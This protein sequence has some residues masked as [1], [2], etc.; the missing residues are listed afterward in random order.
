MERAFKTNKRNFFV[1]ILL[2]TL[3]TIFLFIAVFFALFIP[4]FENTIMDRKR[5]MIKELTNSAWSILDKWHKAEEQG[6]TT[7]EKAQEM[8]ISQIQSLRYGEEAKDYFWITDYSPIMI[9]HPYRSELNKKDLSELKDSHG[10]K[11]FVE[12]AAIATKSG[13]GFVNYMWQWKDDSTKIVPKLSYV[14][15]FPPWQWVIGTGI[16]IEDVRS[17]IAQLEKKIINVSMGI[18]LVISVFLFFIAY[19]SLSTEKQRRRAEVDLHESREKYRALVEASSEGLIMILEEGQIFYNKTLYNILGYNEDIPSLILSELFL[20][21]PAL[22]TIDINTLRIINP[23]SNNLDQVE[24]VIKKADGT[25][26]NVLINASPITFLNSSGV[27]LSVKDISV[28]KMIEA[29][30]DKSK[31]KY[32]ALT[33][34][35]SIGVFRTILKKEFMFVEANN[36]ALNILKIKDQETLLSSSLNDCFEDA[37]D[38]KSFNDDLMKNKSIQNRIV[39]IS[40]PG[41][42]A[43]VS[44]SAILV[45]DTNDDKLYLEGIIEDISE[46]NRTDKARDNLIYELQTAF[47]FLNKS[48]ESFVKQIPSCK[49]NSTVIDAIKILAREKSD[50]LLIED[51]GETKIGFLSE[52]DIRERVLIQKGNLEKS[53]SEFMSSPLITISTNATIFDALSQFYDNDVQHLLFKNSNG[54][55]LG[56]INS[57]DLQNSFHSSYLFFIQKIKNASSVSE[58][59]T[60]HSQLIVLVK[61]LIDRQTNVAD[62]TKIITAIFDAIVTSVIKLAVI[63]LGDPPAK[64]S[65]IIL[66]SAGRSEQTLATDQDNAIIFEDVDSEKELST[67]KYFL[68]LGELVA[69]DLDQIGYNF[70][71]GEVMARNPKWSQPLSAWKNYFTNWVTTASPQDLLDIKIF[72]DFRSVYGDATL[73]GQLQNHIA[74]ITSGYNSFFVYLSESISQ[75]QMS[76]S[77]VKLKSSFDIKMVL[78]PIVDCMRLYSLKKNITETNTIERLEQLYSKGI[79]SKAAYKNILQVYSFLMQKRFEHQSGLY[80]GNQ[81]IDNQIN[82][83]EFSDVDLVLFK[84]SL[85]IIEEMQ[86]K[87]KLEFKGTISL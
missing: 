83:Q 49:L 78:L 80:A 73:T 12:M 60:Y 87:I 69:V 14:K 34:K 56:V 41:Y 18:T 36:A 40:S 47:L 81:L 57:Q 85:S 77:A 24:S 17:E 13:D 54:K 68:K 28:N 26:L 5:E 65:F 22:K 39:S 33:N 72:F 52:S 8:A 25:L 71:K 21:P 74:D 75:F 32:L 3:L 7:K 64:F 46:Q 38:F 61:A 30:L 37:V 55:I 45:K 27:V 84:K 35:L 53:V 67:R 9:M 66:G 31:E 63:K 15:S 4:Q 76:E 82:P 16:Y 79:F 19:Q 10:K 86:N 59:C 1:R 11:L 62:V 48:V 43:V 20:E 23:D 58:L 44:I 42:K 50:C 6:N 2:P 70:C 29:E 51:Q